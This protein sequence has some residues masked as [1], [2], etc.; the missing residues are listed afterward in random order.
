MHEGL[1]TD[2]LATL[3]E[4]S[5]SHP[6]MAASSSARTLVAVRGLHR[7][8]ALEGVVDADPAAAVRPP[9]PAL[10]LPK[11]ISVEDVE[12]LLQAALLG[13]TPLALRDRALFELL[14]G[15]GARISE[16]VGLDVD[17]IDLDARSVRLFGKGVQGAR[18]TGGPVRAGGGHGIPRAR[19]PGAGGARKRHARAAA[20]PARRATVPPE[21]LGGAARPPP[22]G[23]A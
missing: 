13:D 23:P 1:V 19:P 20:R 10:R 3:R 12:R 21:R 5:A 22:N 11:A 15:A 18:R 6:P 9:K 8:L 4:G 17:D 7:F 14:Y 2:F 16:A